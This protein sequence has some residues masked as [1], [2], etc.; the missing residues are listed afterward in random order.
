MYPVVSLYLKV[1]YLA[2][3]IKEC[4]RCLLETL[5][6]ATTTNY[7]CTTPA[8]KAQLYGVIFLSFPSEKTFLPSFLSVAGLNCVLAYSDSPV[9]V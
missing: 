4:K 9:H 8:L 3:I 6:L 5:H 1:I 7:T 2:I